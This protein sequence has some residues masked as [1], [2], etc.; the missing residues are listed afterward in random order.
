M[1]TPNRHTKL[2]LC[3]ALLLSMLAVLPSSTFAAPSEEAK[4]RLAAALPENVT[5]DTATA[6][7]LEAA[8]AS[9]LGAD[10][11]TPK[12]AGDIVQYALSRPG[13]QNLPGE[14]SVTSAL[15]LMQ[16]ALAAAPEG[17]QYVNAITLA[18]VFVVPGLS[19]EANAERERRGM[20]PFTNAMVNRM[21][22][23][24]FEGNPPSG[25][26]TPTS[27]PTPTPAP[28][29]PP[30]G[31]PPGPP[32]GLPPGPPQGVPPPVNPPMTPVQNT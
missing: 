17:D 12:L 29:G 4:Q 28:Q 27:T 8:V 20:A 26:P 1:K 2:W 32:Q 18:T 23:Q 19:V 10:G 3:L 15:E 11:I 9:A 13:I 16:A 21:V 25:V 24:P 14:Q 31:V 22:R 30:Q 7:Q 5:P 6:E